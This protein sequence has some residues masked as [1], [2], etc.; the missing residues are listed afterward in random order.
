MVLKK[1]SLMSLFIHTHQSESSPYEKPEKPLETPCLTSEKLQPSNQP[2]YYDQPKSSSDLDALVVPSPTTEEFALFDDDPFASGSPSLCDQPLHASPKPSFMSVGSAYLFPMP[3]GVPRYTHKHLSSYSSFP[4]LRSLTEIDAEQTNYCLPTASRTN[5]EYYQQPLHHSPH[6]IPL[7]LRSSKLKK[8]VVPDTEFR[9]DRALT[10]L[11]PPQPSFY[12]RHRTSSMNY[13]KRFGRSFI[14][15]D[16]DFEEDHH[17]DHASSW[18]RR[19]NGKGKTDSLESVISHSSW[20]T[21][22]S[23]RHD[24]ERESVGSNS[25][26]NSIRHTKPFETSRLVKMRKSMPRIHGLMSCISSK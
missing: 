22:Y 2:M 6:V 16:D 3:P 1:R 25:W 15:F 21:R 5:L 18:S 13:D 24:K 8:T 20:A 26:D 12:H 19:G 4:S 7:P 17:A 23:D 10:P 11:S 9:D 14:Q